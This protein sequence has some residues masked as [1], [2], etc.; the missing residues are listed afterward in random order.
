MI[1]ELE[2]NRHKASEIVKTELQ[3]FLKEHLEK[4]LEKYPFSIIIDESSDITK[5][6][7]LAI[8]VQYFH[9]DHGMQCKLHS[10]K[11]CSILSDAEALFK[12]VES[13]IVNKPYG[14][15]LFGYLSDGAPVMKGE[16]NSILSRLHNHYTNLW[17]IYCPNHGIHLA[18]SDASTVIPDK[19]E[20]FLEKSYK[21][22]KH[23]P[24]R[25]SR[26]NTIVEGMDIPVRKVLRPG[27]TRWLS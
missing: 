4:D 20:D 25:V 19:V 27:Q 17:Y 1:K 16:Y 7:F 12:I 14:K 11:E 5:K 3:P 23:P 22:P 9:P 2:M 13:E 15:N 6:K 10:F 18:A 26:I 8:M 24:K 21:Y